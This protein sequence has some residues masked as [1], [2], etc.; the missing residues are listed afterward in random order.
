[1]T[2]KAEFSHFRTKSEIQPMTFLTNVWYCAALSNEITSSPM[3]RV[4]CDMPIA[5]FRTRSGRIAALED[6]CPHRQ[7]PLSR[8]TVV[9]EDIQC[10]Y[11]GFAFDC[12]GA[13]THIPHQTT[14]PRSANILAFPL[15]ERWGYAWIWWGDR[16]A[17]DP[18]QIPDLPWT[19]DDKWRSVYFYFHVKAN[20]QLMADNLLDVSHIDF[21][22][23]QSIGSAAGAKGQHDTPKIDLE[24]KTEGEKIYYTRKVYGTNLGGVAKKWIGSEKKVNRISRQSWEKPNTIHFATTLE[25]EDNRVTF[26]MDHLMTPETAET[27]HYFMNWTR[28]FGVQNIGYPTDDDI[29]RE[30]LSVVELEDIPMVEAQHKNIMEFGSEFDVAARQDQFIGHVHR[31]LQE[32]YGKAGLPFP[33]EVRRTVRRLAS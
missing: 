24:S 23:R 31:M 32:L 5:L 13:C 26:R 11:H 20:H 6:R 15:I 19:E 8:G 16:S 29:R 4:I 10:N 12:Q 22:H 28:D 33:P 30:Q 18:L 27:T 9:G 14:L 7:A 25:N 3:R 17:M 2:F 1:L 21:L